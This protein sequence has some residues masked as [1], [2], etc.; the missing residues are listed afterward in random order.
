MFPPC[1]QCLCGPI[2]SLYIWSP[3][4]WISPG[5]WH[6]ERSEHVGEWIGGIFIA[7]LGSVKRLGRKCFGKHKDLSRH[8]LVLVAHA[9]TFQVK[10]EK[11][12]QLFVGPSLASNT[13]FGNPLASR[14]ALTLPKTQA[15]NTVCEARKGWAPGFLG[16]NSGAVNDSFQNTLLPKIVAWHKRRVHTAVVPSKDYTIGL[17]GGTEAAWFSP[18]TGNEVKQR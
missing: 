14:P 16:S 13:W 6:Q 10:K 18:M 7:S 9:E 1:G 11:S 15:G 3:R 5:V 4:E 12:S 8:Y 17:L 2:C